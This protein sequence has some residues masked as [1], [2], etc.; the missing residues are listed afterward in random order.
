MD[1]RTYRQLDAISA[2]AIKAG[3]RSMRAMRNEMTGIRKPASPSMIMGS[4]VHELLFSSVL[5]DR[6]SIFDGASRK[7]KAFDAFEEAHKGRD[8]A[9]YSELE[10]AR[11]YAVNALARPAIKRLI[12]SAQNEVVCA[13]VDP[14]YGNAKARLDGQGDDCAIEIKT[15]RDI[16]DR[17]FER[18]FY[19]MGYDMQLGWYDRAFQ[20]RG[21]TWWVIAIQT[22][23]E[24]DARLVK[25]P[26]LVIREGYAKAKAIAMR[27]RECERADVW[28]GV[29]GGQDYTVFEPPVWAVGNNEISMEGVAEI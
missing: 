5:S 16:S 25:I 14:E 27:Y 20:G 29:D 23:D 28:P 26:Q 11:V 24:P 18:A 19:G 21:L 13:W 9:L 12:D 8:I 1:E 2:T 10:E 22:G 7:S 4:L 15:M 17:G 3:A 6:W